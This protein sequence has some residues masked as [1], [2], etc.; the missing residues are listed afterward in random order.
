LLIF[1]HI[2]KGFLPVLFFTCPC[3]WWS[4]A[5][6]L[7]F[8][9]FRKHF[10]PAKRLVFLTLYHLQ[11]PPEVFHV[12][13]WQCNRVKHKKQRWHNATP[14][15]VLPFSW[16]GSQTPP[17]MSSTYD[18]LRH[19]TAMPLQVRIEEGPR[20]KAVRV[21]G[22]QY[23]QY[24][25][26]KISLITLLLDTYKHSDFWHKIICSVLIVGFILT[27]HIS[28]CYGL[29]GPGIE[30]RWRRGFRIRPG[31]PWYPPILL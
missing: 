6:L 30:S 4:S 19:Y 27:L 1:D 5:A 25:Q 21:G 8:S 16:R 14:C 12:L 22:Q 23:C 9:A 24:S 11:R 18:T 13:W 28:S 17:D 3:F 20:S 29:D 2:Q 15:S 10:V 7:I 31:L 26:E